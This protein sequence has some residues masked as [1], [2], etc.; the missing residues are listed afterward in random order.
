M[1]LES[2]RAT[3]SGELAERPDAAKFQDIIDSIKLSVRD[4]ENRQMKFKEETESVYHDHSHSLD[5][6]KGRL[7]NIIKELERR[8]TRDDEARIM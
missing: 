3:T 6:M 8:L 5:H 4:C 1:M 2:F 7:S